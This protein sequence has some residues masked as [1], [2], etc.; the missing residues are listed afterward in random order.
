MAQIP[1]EARANRRKMKVEGLP[2]S[3]R[4]APLLPTERKKE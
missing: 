1:G 2:V 3:G 4:R